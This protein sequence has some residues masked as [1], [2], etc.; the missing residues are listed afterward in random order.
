VLRVPRTS[1]SPRIVSL[2]VIA[3]LR[4]RR[5]DPGHRELLDE[6]WQLAEPTG[7][8]YRLWPVATA[9]AESAWL[10]G[11]YEAVEEAS[12]KTLELAVDLKVPVAVG[13][14][15]IWRLRAGFDDGLAA[16]AAEP[17]AIELHGDPGGAAERWAELGSPYEEA[18][19]LAQTDDVDA[20]GL[21]HDALQRLGAQPA[22]AW[23][24]RRLRERGASVARGARPAT[25]DN[26]AHLTARELEVL[27]L[28]AEGLRN[29][30]IA[31]RLFLSQ[32]TVDHHVSAILRKLAV[33]TR[34]EAGAA[35]AR[36]GLIS[37]PN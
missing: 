20:L 14:L 16:V 17:Y 5:G 11:D 37:A 4:A 36:L 23:V 30:D 29:A 19:A 27:G 22:A 10:H 18:L 24:A 1:I 9:R 15:S 25:R 7:E 33:R 2:V 21:A 13:E 32:K 3:L 6:A 35:G 31:Q 28:V 26:P 34:G 8:L 12:Q